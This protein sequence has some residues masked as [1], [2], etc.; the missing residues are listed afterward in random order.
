VGT[1]DGVKL[2]DHT[3]HIDSRGDVHNATGYDAR[4][5][6]YLD[7]AATTPLDPR[8]LEIMLPYLSDLFGNPSSVHRRGR[9]SR[10]AVESARERV[11]ENLGAEPAEV[12]F[13][14]GGSEADNLAIL[15]AGV[16]A[17]DTVLS[18]RAEHE[19][20]LRPIERLQ[21]RG[22]RVVWCPVDR[23]ARCD[24]KS[25]AEI[26]EAERPALVSVTLVNNETG[27]LNDIAALAGICRE[28]GCVVH[29][30][31]VQAADLYDIDVGDLG[32]DLL[33]LSAH[34]LH[35]PKGAGCLFVRGGLELSSLL[36]GGQQERARRAGT[37]NVA[38]IVGFAAALDLARAERALR[39]VH[40]LG[41]RRRLLHGLSETLGDLIE[42][43]SGDEEECA[44]H[45]LSV[46][47]PPT[48]S[49]VI[50]GEMLLLNLDVE[51]VEV[52]AGSACTSGSLKPSHVLTAAG[53]P[54][55]S[56]AAAIRFSLGKDNTPEEID[57]TVQIV[58]SVVS[59]MT[60]RRSA[61]S[62]AGR[63]A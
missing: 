52:S 2:E 54:A 47:I 14:S 9:E 5:R 40:I 48:E 36:L 8:V 44:P 19:A 61:P 21:E 51:G 31:A 15:G 26:L 53:W 42:V 38:G 27:A 30:D 11:A 45:I 22:V 3:L 62:P 41:L 6:I 60:Q 63:G 37:E 49:R 29:T 20:V 33:A 28:L 10:H 17:G 46:V 24:T 35:G 57:R 13:T 23:H 32:I 1:F 50:D 59:R 12:V 7:H 43:V 4:E 16:G 25:V 58:S 55:E 18:T 56:A 34:K 39:R